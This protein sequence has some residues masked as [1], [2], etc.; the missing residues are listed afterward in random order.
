MERSGA[1][2]VVTGGRALSFHH[3]SMGET[4]ALSLTKGMRSPA[5]RAGRRDVV[6]K[7]Q[8]GSLGTEEKAS[9]LSGYLPPYANT[10]ER[11][12]V[13]VSPLGS[14]DKFQI[15][16]IRTQTERQFRPGCGR[17]P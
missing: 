2:S 15:D 11:Y 8:P 14:L 4:A 13:F 3:V 12:K 5:R 16:V 17:C 10:Y 6:R 7:G 9:V 1:F